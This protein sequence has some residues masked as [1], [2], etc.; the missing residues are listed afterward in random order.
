[1]S[2]ELACPE[3]GNRS[4]GWT[5]SQVQY[6]SVHEFPD[7]SRDVEALDSGPVVDDD[8]ETEGVYCGECDRSYKLDELVRPNKTDVAP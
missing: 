4:F 6:G 8:V 2:T 5:I 7:K 1:M 3:C